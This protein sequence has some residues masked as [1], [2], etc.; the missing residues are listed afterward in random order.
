MTNFCCLVI[1]IMSIHKIINIKISFMCVHFYNQ[2]ISNFEYCIWK[3]NNLIDINEYA[4]WEEKIKLKAAFYQKTLIFW[5]ELQNTEHHYWQQKYIPIICYNWYFQS[6][7]IEVAQ[8]EIFMEQ[9]MWAGFG[10]VGNTEKKSLG[11]L[12]ATFEDGFFMFSGA[13]K[14]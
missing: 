12:W 13:K 4:I 10:P 1:I 7:Y 14:I 2:I 11:R 3:L 9:K 5:S 8:G 6:H